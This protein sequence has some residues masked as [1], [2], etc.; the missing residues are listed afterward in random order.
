M[1]S[2][3]ATIAY[4]V[5]YVFFIALWLR[6]IFDCVRVLSHWHRLAVN[7]QPTQQ[8][9]GLQGKLGDV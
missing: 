2:L 9:H 6:F 4:I 1:I 8:L 3:L 7:I 5:L